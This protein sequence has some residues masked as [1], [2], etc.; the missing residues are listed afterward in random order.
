MSRKCIL[1]AGNLSWVYKFSV[2]RLIHSIPFVD[3]KTESAGGT[4]LVN[5]PELSV[6]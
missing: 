2:P 4:I 1:R 5:P 6:N 3:P